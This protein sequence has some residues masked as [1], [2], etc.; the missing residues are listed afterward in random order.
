MSNDEKEIYLKEF[1]LRVKHY[2]LSQHI[3]LEEL[4]NKCGYTSATSRSTIQKIE[5]GKSDV[6]ASKIVK[7]AKALGVGIS[8]LLDGEEQETILD[9]NKLVTG[10]YGEPVGTLLPLVAKLDTE[11][12]AEIRG[13]VKGMLKSDKYTT[14]KELFG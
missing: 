4:A 11:D 10:H 5:A 13:E 8:A 6:P 7:L 1:G 3:T 9:I 14:E 12:L 2:R